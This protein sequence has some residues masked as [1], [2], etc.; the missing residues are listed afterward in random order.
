MAFTPM[1]E[2]THSVVSPKHRWLNET[3][4]W[5]CC[6][7]F[8]IVPHP[9]FRLLHLM[10]HKHTNDPELDPDYIKPTPACLVVFRIWATVFGWVRHL[11]RNCRSVSSSAWLQSALFVCTNMAVITIG[12]HRGLGFRLLQFWV[13]PTLGG[14]SILGFLFS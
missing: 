8:I 5:L 4:G 3:I 14:I 6:W 13:L 7:P 2:A 9:L 10:H 11:R 1:H 12:I